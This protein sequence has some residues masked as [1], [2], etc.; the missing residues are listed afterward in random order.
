MHVFEITSAGGNLGTKRV[1]L[2]N[3]ERH[4]ADFCS[5]LERGQLLASVTVAVTAGDT[6]VTAA[7]LS[8]DRKSAIWLISASDTAEN[9]TMTL[10]VTTNDGQTLKYTVGY[11]IG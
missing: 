9:V 5:F 7:V 6:V 8:A 3:I 1:T 2:E 11:V 4:R 10:T